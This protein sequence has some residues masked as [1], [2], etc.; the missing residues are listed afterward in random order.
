MGLGLLH[1]LVAV[2]LFPPFGFQISQQQ[3]SMEG[4]VERSKSLASDR[5][6]FK[7]HICHA[8][9]AWPRPSVLTCISVS[10]IVKMGTVIA[11]SWGCVGTPVA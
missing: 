5:P 4:L 2:P 8:L 3:K 7:S 9:S 6:E 11:P 1:L 10:S